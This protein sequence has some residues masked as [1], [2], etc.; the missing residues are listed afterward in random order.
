[1]GRTV[2]RHWDSRTYTSRPTGPGDAPR[3]VFQAYVPH[4]ISGWDPDLSL[5]TWMVVSS[6]TE[7]CRRIQ[8]SAEAEP[9]AGEWLLGRAESIASSTI[10]GI[11]PSA[12]RVARAEARL[13][14]F[15]ETPTGDEMQALRNIE[16]TQHARD[17]A[18]GRTE[19]TVDSLR[20]LHTTL[21]GED[22]PIAGRI[23]TQQNWVGGGS[24][25]GPMEASHV[26]PPARGR[27]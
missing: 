27:A 15:G 7:R 10:E 12:R 2:A 24:L 25:G 4:P 19:L 13:D 11:R 23:R 9:F 22:D 1:M 14:L 18:E 5:S 6:A 21:M 26:G 3:T 8:R 17:L 20:M 16:V